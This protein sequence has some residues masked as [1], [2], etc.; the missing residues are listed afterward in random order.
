VIEWAGQ[1]LA[2]EA[3][4]G[5]TL[6]VAVVSGI[7]AITLQILKRGPA[8]AEI[9]DKARK[10]LDDST[11]VE[12]KRL[13]ERVDDAERRHANCEEQLDHQRAAVRELQD[14]MTGLRRQLIQYEQTT[15]TML[16]NRETAPKRRKP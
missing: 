16:R 4:R 12:L 7:T 6:L 2:S 8:I 5:A 11:Q 1:L 9:D 13:A 3:F 14:D 10:A 15:V